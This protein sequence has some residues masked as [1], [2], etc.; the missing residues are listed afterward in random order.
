MS[1]MNIGSV[2][3]AYSAYSTT[4]KTDTAAAESAPKSDVNAAAEAGVVY[5]KG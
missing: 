4:A 1:D 2:T 5:E 3:S